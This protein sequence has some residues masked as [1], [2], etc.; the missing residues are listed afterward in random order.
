MPQQASINYGPGNVRMRGRGLSAYFQDD[1]RFRGNLT[2]NVGVRYELIWP[3]LETHGH[4]VNLD[5]NDTF[6]SAAPVL[7]G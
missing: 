7:S 3:Y 6:T 1:W 4:M 2:F 5:V